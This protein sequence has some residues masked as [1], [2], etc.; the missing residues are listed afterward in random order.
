MNRTGFFPQPHYHQFLVRWCVIIAPHRWWRS[1]STIGDLPD[2][3]AEELCRAQT[4]Q[5]KAQHSTSASPPSAHKSKVV[6]ALDAAE[7]GHHTSQQPFL[8][9]ASIITCS[10]KSLLNVVPWLATT[11][12]LTDLEKIRIPPPWCW[13]GICMITVLEMGWK[14]WFEWM[15]WEVHKDTVGSDGVL[16]AAWWS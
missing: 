8:V 2:I 3:T 11:Q 16:P 4:Q 10:R 1:L 14:D 5:D 15:C 12:P 6:D 9:I 7:G 13:E